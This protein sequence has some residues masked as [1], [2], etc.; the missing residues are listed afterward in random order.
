M[1]EYRLRAWNEYKALP[2]PGRVTLI[3]TIAQPLFTVPDHDLGWGCVAAGVDVHVLNTNHDSLIKE[4]DVQWLANAIRAVLD[5]AERDLGG[6][7]ART[8]LTNRWLTCGSCA[9]GPDRDIASA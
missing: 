4:P 3:R 8:C 6:A 7:D 2:Y 9:P 1:M 5:N